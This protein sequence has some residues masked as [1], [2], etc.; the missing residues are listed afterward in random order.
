MF[1]KFA[2]FV[3]PRP[4][5]CGNGRR[6]WAKLPLK[7]GYGRVNPAATTAGSVMF[8]FSSSPR[9]RYLEST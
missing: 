1:P 3:A 4:E 7:L 9:F 8:R 2:E 5:Y 6:D